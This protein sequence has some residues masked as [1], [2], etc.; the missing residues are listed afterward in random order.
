MY[1]RTPE[2]NW[3]FSAMRAHMNTWSFKLRADQAFSYAYLLV[4]VGG[5]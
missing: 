5:V 2:S 1:M 4:I 3:V